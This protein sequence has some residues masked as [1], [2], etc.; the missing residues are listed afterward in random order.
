MRRSGRQ[1]QPPLRRMQDG[2]RRPRPAVPGV[3]GAAMRR[4]FTPEERAALADLLGRVRWLWL[5]EP[6]DDIYERLRE[7]ISGDSPPTSVVELAERVE[8]AERMAA[9]YRPPRET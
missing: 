4:R 2:R 1:R 3:R 5:H 7:V 6:D 9:D 8:R